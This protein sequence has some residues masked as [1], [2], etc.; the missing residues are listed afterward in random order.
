MDDRVEPFTDEQALTWLRAQPHGRIETTI[1]DLARQWVWNRTKVLR[2]LKRWVADGH[3]VRAIEPSGRSVITA[4]KPAV[5]RATLVNTN[6]PIPESNKL[7]ATAAAASVHL[8][9][10]SEQRRRSI[11]PTRRPRAV[12]SRTASLGLAALA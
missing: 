1:S 9:E 2:R 10:P 6:V 5:R 3:V 4:S 7:P 12:L 8:A 11:T